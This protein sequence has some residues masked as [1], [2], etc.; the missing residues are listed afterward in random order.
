M[1]TLESEKLSNHACDLGPSDFICLGALVFS[2]IK[3]EK[4]E[5]LAVL[6]RG[7]KRINLLNRLLYRN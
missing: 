3:W 2:S 4:H 5:P 1:W 6:I 7:V